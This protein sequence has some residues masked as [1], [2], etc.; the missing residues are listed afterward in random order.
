MRLPAAF[1][2]PLAGIVG[3]I[4]ISIALMAPGI[5]LSFFA[6]GLLWLVA[7][8]F[9][10]AGAYPLAGNLLALALAD[11]R[12]IVLDGEAVEIRYGFS[13]R[14]FRFVDYSDFGITWLGPRKVLA[15]APVARASGRHAP[16]VTI[17]NRP[18]L[19]TPMPPL[20]SGAPA[21]LAEWQATL[22]ALRQAAIAASSP[23]R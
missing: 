20:G 17:Y 2:Y 6:S 12:K 4:A 19:I 15:A 1:E 18:A 23:S 8:L 3:R 16:Y 5:V 9:L 7:G 21:T 14:R 13:R 10:L 11:R 22:N